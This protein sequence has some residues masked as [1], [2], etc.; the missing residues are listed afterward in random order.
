[1]TDAEITKTLQT[2]FKQEA[3]VWKIKDDLRQMVQFQ[4]ANLLDNLSHLGM[5]DVI[6]CRNVLIYFNSETKSH[7]LNK[8]ASR[9][10][11]D[12]MLFLGACE[13]IM[14]LPVSFSSAPGHHGVF[15]L[16]ES[17]AERKVFS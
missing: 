8:M 1:M 7:V 9:L 5:Y 13:T 15:K 14:N 3:A 17:P 4:Y 11:P 16:K 2:H 12:G 6:F 10:S